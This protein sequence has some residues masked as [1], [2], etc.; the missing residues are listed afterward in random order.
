[1]AGLV[2]AI[3]VLHNFGMAGGFIYFLT[4]RPNGIL[5]V[6]VPEE[7][8]PGL[9]K[10]IVET[11]VGATG[12]AFVID[13]KGNWIVSPDG[14]AE[15]EGARKADRAILVDTDVELQPLAV[16]KLVKA[17]G[18]TG[19]RGGAY[20]PR[21]SPYSFQGHKEKGL[22]ML[23]VAREQTGLA[24]VTEVMAPE[25]VPLVCQERRA[26]NFPVTQSREISK[27]ISPW[28]FGPLPSCDPRLETDVRICPS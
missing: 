23:A 21:T 27:R 11:R 2:P 7:N 25:H 15:S 18:A 4:N 9:R 16:A 3:H 20:K 6:G 24:I 14:K 10:A 22:E 17:A 13:S 12:R 5:Y 8:V 1:M 19:L 26:V 28:R